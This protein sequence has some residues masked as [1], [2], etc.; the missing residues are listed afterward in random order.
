MT[1]ERIDR[2]RTLVLALAIVPLTAGCSIPLKRLPQESW[3]ASPA[4][5]K[6]LVYVVSSG[7]GW[8]GGFSYH[9]L[10]DRGGDADRFVGTLITNAYFTLE[11]EPGEHRLGV[12]GDTLDL[13]DLDVRPGE[14]YHVMV[15]S[16]LAPSRHGYGHYKYIAVN[17]PDERLDDALEMTGEVV[18]TEKG[19]REAIGHQR[20][21]RAMK[22]KYT[23]RWEASEERQR[24]DTPTPHP[25][26]ES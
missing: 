21:L 12:V 4:E 1:V 7:A 20:R 22:P 3:A 25:S 5:G 19:E 15:G 17:G 18:P 8:G 10:I 9:Y 26:R 2:L 6:A 24:V 23:P 13:I 14:T 11:L 16:Y